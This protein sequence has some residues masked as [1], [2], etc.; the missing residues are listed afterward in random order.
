[1]RL[2][3]LSLI[4]ILYIIYNKRIML[5]HNIIYYKRIILYIILYIISILYYGI[6]LYI[7]SVL[8]NILY[9]YNE[10]TIPCII[11]Y[12]YKT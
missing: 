8:Y 12:G 7:I 5:W 9:A 10:R 2:K 1:M 11:C 4:I 6:I 3:I